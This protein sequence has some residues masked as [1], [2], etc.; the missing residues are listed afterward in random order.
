MVVEQVARVYKDYSFE[1]PENRCADEYVRMHV[2]RTSQPTSDTYGAGVRTKR[3]HV[4]IANT[5][6]H[7]NFVAKML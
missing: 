4:Y 6:T 1:S 2:A 5:Y 7:V 3:I